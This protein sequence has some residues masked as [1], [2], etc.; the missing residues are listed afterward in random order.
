[1]REILVHLDDGERSSARLDIAIGLAARFK[2]RLTGL[3]A[4]S[5]SD[6]SSA[7]AQR[8]SDRLLAARASVAQDFDAKTAAAGITARWWELSHGAPDH[9]LSETMFCARYADLVVMGQ[10]GLDETLVPKDLVERT[11]L[12]CGRPVLVIPRHGHFPVVGERVVLAWNASREAVRA[13][14]DSRPLLAGARSVTVLSVLDGKSGGE[15]NMV[16]VPRVDIIDYLE[17]NGVSARLERLAG[18]DVGKMDLL[19]SRIC[20]LGADLIVMGAHGGKGLSSKNGAD[21]RYVLAH[22]TVPVLMSC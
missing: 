21:T 13:M 6:R 14:A 1:M 9:V 20:D 11:I 22:M 15:A 17:A 19:L 18:E 2:A 3:F 16:E 5:D 4:R 12:N 7:V 8:P 10:Q